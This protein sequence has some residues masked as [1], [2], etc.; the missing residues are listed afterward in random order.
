MKIFETYQRK[1]TVFSFEIFPPKRTVGIETLYGTLDRLSALSPD[2]ISVTYG[3][4]GSAEQNLTFPLA[5]HIKKD[6]GVEPLAHLTCVGSSREEIDFALE[7]LK[8]WQVENVLALR[9]DRRPEITRPGDFSHASDLTRHIRDKGF[10]GV[11]GA[12][13]PEGHFECAS[14]EEDLLH[15]KYKQEC[16]AQFFISQLFFDN[17]DFYRFLEKARGRGI[18]RPISAGIMPVC[19][20]KQIQRIVS[21]SGAKLPAKFSRIMALYENDPI[22]L[23]DA[24]IAYATEQIVD[25]ITSGVQGIHLYTMNNPDVASKITQNIASILGTVN[26]EN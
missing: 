19:S 24:G 23:R 16:G 1:K 9:G 17:G 25:L 13:Y 26:K 8:A 14:M 6:Y 21:L 11:G 22:A 3:A 15:L 10:F 2:F 12:C 5:A 18:D 4:G 20:A 7:Q